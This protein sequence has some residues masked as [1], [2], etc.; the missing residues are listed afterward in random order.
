MLGGRKKIRPAIICATD[1]QRKQ[2]KKEK[3]GESG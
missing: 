2:A 3:G 1:P